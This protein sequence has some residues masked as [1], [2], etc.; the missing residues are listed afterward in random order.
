MAQKEE[1]YVGLDIGTSKIACVV[2]K[3]ESEDHL[4]IIGIGTSRS[5]GIKKGVVA[6]IEETISGISE[7]IEVA[8]RMAGIDI[9]SASVNINGSTIGS[10]NSNG[11]VAVGRPISKLSQRTSNV[12]K[13]P[14]R[15][16]RYPQTRK[17]FTHSLE[18]LRWTIKKA[19]KTQLG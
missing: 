16:F 2:A 1:T 8:E 15:P 3:R 5:T 4:S 6:E 19:S 11:V 13:M 12:L 17:F 14:L 10:L 18:Y 9:S 7:A